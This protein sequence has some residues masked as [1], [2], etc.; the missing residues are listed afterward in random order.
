MP[1][2]DPTELIKRA[3]TEYAVNATNPHLDDL[4][5]TSKSSYFK[6]KK[7]LWIYLTMTQADLLSTRAA[8][9]AEAD[10]EELVSSVTDR[11]ARR[12]FGLGACAVKF[13]AES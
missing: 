11:L 13:T 12:E 2:P 5:K 1:N 7:R 8:S 3:L 10:L 9:S 6:K 4:V